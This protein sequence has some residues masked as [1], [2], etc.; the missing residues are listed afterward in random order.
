[1]D[2]PWLR[3]PWAVPP[4]AHLIAQ[5]IAANHSSNC[6]LTQLLNGCRIMLAFLGAR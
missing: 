5:L 6:I 2:G 4:R 3:G 1:M